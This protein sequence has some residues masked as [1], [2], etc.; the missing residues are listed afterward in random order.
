L[1]IDASLAGLADIVYPDAVVHPL[2]AH[3]SQAGPAELLE[4]SRRTLAELGALNFDEVY[5]LNFSGL[6]FALARLFDPAIVRGY[7][8]LGA[9]PL[10]DRWCELGFRIA[11]KRRGLGL[12][13]VDFWGLL[14]RDR[15]DVLPP[16]S[17]DPLA[18]GKGG[19]VGV[20]LAGRNVRRS[21]PADVLAGVVQ[22]VAARESARR[23]VLLGMGS[24]RRLAGEVLDGMRPAFRDR[25][26]NLCGKT[27]LSGLAEVVGELDM[28]LTPDTGTMHLACMLGTPVTAF[29]L[30]SAWCFETGPYGAG[31]TVWQA[32]TECAPCVESQP[33]VRRGPDA[34]ACLSPFSQP[35]FLKCL[36]G[37][38][39]PPEGV[40]GLSTTFDRVGVGYEAFAGTDPTAASR[41]A[42]RSFLRKH[43]YADMAGE[44]PQLGYAEMLYQERDWLV[45]PYREVLNA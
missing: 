40:V 23:V 17:V 27:N 21:L 42:F 34:L 5:N 29:F 6:N 14:A 7:A 8:S 45:E 2:P 15:R 38:G 18:Q 4:T 43:L 3:G 44:S 41:A 39:E 10:K 25:V 37:K 20:V 28:V 1:A 36:L 32:T 26:E 33:C 24:E 9:Q 31:H 22:A 19:G 13:L 30:S 35:G 12:N 16:E 11:K